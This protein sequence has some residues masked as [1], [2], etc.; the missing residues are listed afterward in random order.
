LA[1]TSSRKKNEERAQKATVKK[2]AELGEKEK[3]INSKIKELNTKD[4]YLEAYSDG[5]A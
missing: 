3:L 2:L 4:L 1:K 5:R